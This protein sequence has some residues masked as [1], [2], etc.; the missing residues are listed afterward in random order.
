MDGPRDRSQIWTAQKRISGKFLEECSVTPY[1]SL[2]YMVTP[3][4]IEPVLQP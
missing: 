2:I 4:G 1:K 3:T